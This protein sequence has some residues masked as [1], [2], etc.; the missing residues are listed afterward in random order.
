MLDTAPVEPV[1]WLDDDIAPE[2]DTFLTVEDVPDFPGVMDGT[3]GSLGF[4]GMTTS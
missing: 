1:V 3:E 4:L 2:F